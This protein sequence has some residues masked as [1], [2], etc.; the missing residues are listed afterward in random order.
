MNKWVVAGVT[1]A[2]LGGVAYLMYKESKEA[3]P[4]AKPKPATERIEY[5]RGGRPGIEPRMAKPPIW[6]EPGI[7]PVKHAE[8]QKKA[9]LQVKQPVPPSPFRK[10]EGGEAPMAAKGY[11]SAVWARGGPQPKCRVK[12][13]E[14]PNRN[15]PLERAWAQDYCQAVACKGTHE[16]NTPLGKIKFECYW[17]MPE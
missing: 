12:I 9:A 17:E 11:P 1:I 3:R 5:R 16:I 4:K 6:V 10:E 2:A 15:P 8:I 13:I 14:A 7:I